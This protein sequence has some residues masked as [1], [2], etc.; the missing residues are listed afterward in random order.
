MKTAVYSS[1]SPKKENIIVR[2][3]VRQAGA[4]CIQLYHNDSH[5]ENASG[6]FFKEYTEQLYLDTWAD[7][8]YPGR[9]WQPITQGKQYLQNQRSEYQSPYHWSSAHSSV[10]EVE[11]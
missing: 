8:E 5:E 9:S 11:A 7:G 1:Q 6:V 4:I 3:V 10:V 2:P